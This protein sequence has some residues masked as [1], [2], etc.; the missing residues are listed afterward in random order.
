MGEER[1]FLSTDDRLARLREVIGPDVAPVQP[2]AVPGVRAL[3][4]LIPWCVLAA[5]VFVWFGFRPDLDA[6]GVRSQAALSLAQVAA[7]LA[8]VRFSLRSSIPGLMPATS[9]AMMI[10]AG[11]VLLHLV[12]GWDTVARG[13]LAFPIGREWSVGLACLGAIAVMSV[14]SLIVGLTMLQNGVLTRAL[15]AAVLVGTAAGLMAESIWRLH[16]PYSTWGH[17][18]PFHT[19]ALLM[20]ILLAAGLATWRQRRDESAGTALAT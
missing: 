11:A 20:P 1:R 7:C 5:G 13:W 15:S 8:I 16:C 10:T 9:S 2:L 6:L 17:L 12:I 3:W 14:P 4:V 18:L 19:G